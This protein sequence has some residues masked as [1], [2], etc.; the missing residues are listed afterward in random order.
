MS[1][2]KE[3]QIADAKAK[4]AAAA[5]AKVAAM[6]KLKEKEAANNIEEEQVVEAPKAE[7][8]ETDAKAKAVAAAKAKVA[9]VVKAKA[10]AAAKA[11]VAAQ[12]SESN[13][14]PADT[15]DDA[16]AKAVA[17]AK[18]KAA[19][20]AKAKAAANAKT[21]GGA[22]TGTDDEKAKAKAA[23]VAKAK[24]AA[25]AKAK[26][27]TGEAKVAEPVAEKPSPNQPMLD[28]YLK[29]IK[30]NLNEN[31]IEE[32]YINRLSKDVPTLV[33]NKDE[34]FKVAQFLKH[35]ELLSFDYLSNHHGS[36]FETHMEIYNHFYSFKTKESIA[37]KTKIDRDEPIIDSLVP[38]WEGANWPE[39]ESYDLLGIKYTGHPDLT[40]IML[41]D[42]WVGHPLRKDYVQHDE[43]V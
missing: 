19:A 9:A 17:I 29:A 36:D 10:A 11:K 34:Y 16:K 27:A 33:V 4:A 37:L 40:R 28:R 12:G 32:A 23:A 5:K 6:K 8:A 39:R 31:V 35:N 38:I 22:A 26:T 15:T 13:N 24:A 20:A 41:S 2:D 21:G 43:E 3:K 25:A 1:E 18:A 42:D 7:E 30:E 14:E